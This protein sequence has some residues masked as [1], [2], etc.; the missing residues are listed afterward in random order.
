MRRGV[1]FL[2]EIE[3][4]KAPPLE[5]VVKNIYENRKNENKDDLE[6]CND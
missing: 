4:G 3:L 2:T 6:N 5:Y 1:E